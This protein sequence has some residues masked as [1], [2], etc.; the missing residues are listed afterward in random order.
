MI[1]ES[2]LV[3]LLEQTDQSSLQLAKSISEQAD[4]IVKAIQGNEPTLGY[5]KSLAASIVQ[6]AETLRIRDVLRSY[7]R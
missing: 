3:A 4:W 7:K 1:T 2:D 6:L 5:S